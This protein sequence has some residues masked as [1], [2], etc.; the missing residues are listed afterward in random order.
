MN[1]RL[2]TMKT[3]MTAAALALMTATF[4]Y[5]D[6]NPANDSGSFTVRITPN[7]DLGVIVDTTGANWVG[8][9]TTLEDLT[10]DLGTD[11]LLQAPVGIAMAG[12]FANQELTLSGAALNTWQLDT[13]EVDVEDQ[14]R[15][16]GMFGVSPVVSGSPIVGD[17]SGTGNLITG[18]VTRA[19]QAQADEGGN[20]NHAYEL[21]TGN[22]EYADVD[23][24]S[25][26]A[27]R[28]LWLRARTP[29]STST[30]GQASFTVTVTAV[31]GVAL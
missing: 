22:A 7:V 27:T 20:T 26:T 29:S 28:K 5:A 14:M 4:A 30:G 8:A 21:L 23:G 3:M 13:D 12:N 11:T 18:S 6:A 9:S 25:A 31:T 15:L 24:M 19:G 10:S 1:T 16:Y 17:F 2:K